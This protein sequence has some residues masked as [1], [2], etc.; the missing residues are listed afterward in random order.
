MTTQHTQRLALLR[1]ECGHLQQ[2]CAHLSASQERTRDLTSRLHE[3]LSTDELERLEALASRFARLADLLMQ[4]ILRLVDEIELVPGGSLLDRIHRAEKRGWSAQAGDLARIRELRNLI[5]HEYAAEQLAQVYQAV[6][7][8]TPSLIG[9]R[10][11]PR[12]SGR[13]R[14]ARTPQASFTAANAAFAVVRCIGESRR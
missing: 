1:L 7:A 3:N 2:A 10:V 9:M 6:A 4:R 13:G 8:L 11:K 12:P 5:A 14:I